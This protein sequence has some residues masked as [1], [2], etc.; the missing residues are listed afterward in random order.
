MLHYRL[1]TATESPPDKGLMTFAIILGLW[2][3]CSVIVSPLI[4]WLLFALGN[5]RVTPTLPRQS[6][7]SV[8]PESAKSSVAQCDRLDA[9]QPVRGAARGRTE[10]AWPKG[11]GR[12]AARMSVGRFLRTD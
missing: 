4:G 12:G 7:H 2:F 10:R 5:D 8:L 11:W 9:L 3:A 1:R 6:R